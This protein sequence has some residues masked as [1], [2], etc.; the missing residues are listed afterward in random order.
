MSRWTIRLVARLGHLYDPDT[1]LK[2]YDPEAGVP[3]RRG[4]ITAGTIDEAMRF[5]TVEAAHACYVQV[6]RVEPERPD[7][8]PNRPLTAF[9]IE[10]VRVD[11]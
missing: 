9:T 11:D 1:Y 3:G 6:C 4:L 8:R 7:G 5:D 10:L 2:A